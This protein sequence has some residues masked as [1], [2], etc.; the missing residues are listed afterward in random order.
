MT[1]LARTLV[2]LLA[3]PS[4]AATTA[5]Y[6]VKDLPG[7]VDAR[8][9]LGSL[10]VTIGNTSWFTANS[11]DGLGLQVWKT[12]GTEN[13]TVRVTNFI[14]NGVHAETFV[15][16]INGYILYSGQ[17]G[18][19]DA[20]LALDANGGPP[21]TVARSLF[22]RGVVYNG[23]LYAV[24]NAREVEGG[25]P[26]GLELW[27]TDGTT[28]GTTFADLNPGA[29]SSVSPESLALAGDWMVFAGETPA[30]KGIH[31][32]DGTVA[33]TS[34]LL[35]F[36]AGHDP[37]EA[38]ITQAGNRVVFVYRH[39]GVNHDQLLITDGTEDGT[40]S[41][42][43]RLS[44]FTPGPML[45]G[46]FLFTMLTPGGQITMWSS[47]GTLAGTQQLND[48]KGSPGT[49]GL[50]GAVVNG[51]YFF[52]ST[53]PQTQRRALFTT[54][55][56]PGTTQKVAD[57]ETLGSGG[58][59]RNGRFHFANDTAA[60]GNEWWVSDGTAG[61][62]HIV[63][64]LAAGSRDGV[65]LN[66]LLLRPDGFLAGVNG[67]FG[68]EPWIVDSNASGTRLLK[69]IAVDTPEPGS[70]P[71]KLRAAGARLYFL[72]DAPGHRV[73]GR[74]DGHSTG[75]TTGV[76][77]PT[78]EWWFA[79]AFV[80]GARYY[81]QSQSVLLSTDGT[82]GGTVRIS[83]D[84]GSSHAFRGGVVFEERS[85][86]TFRFSNGISSVTTVIERLAGFPSTGWKLYAANDRVWFTNGSALAVSDGVAPMRRIQPHNGTIG[87]IREVV[88]GPNATYFT[89][90]IFPD[91]R[92]WRTDGTDAGTR[93]VRT[94][95][96][97]PQDFIALPDKLLFTH[98]L[99]LWSTDGTE[100][101]T[102]LLGAPGPTKSCGFVTGSVPL[103]VGNQ[104]FWYARRANGTAALWKSNGTLIGTTE[105]A[106]F[107][108]SSSQGCVTMA[109]LDGRIYFRGFDTAHGAEP[110]VTDGT[111]AGTHLLV[112]L[113]PGTKGSDPRE[114]TTAGSH[115]FFSA[116][117][118]DRGRELWAIR[119]LT[120]RRAAAH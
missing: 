109:A 33:G 65:I 114:L 68:H 119:Q 108:S 100:A 35:A 77:T 86:S 113:Y 104:L 88:E 26:K 93:I 29:A 59:A 34:L 61:G 55:A 87:T 57:L 112:D 24:A 44:V 72:A 60:F 110:W 64:D 96:H 83:S 28:E 25:A 58:G 81:L 52:F 13:G 48:H 5:P 102:V 30:G 39:P 111:S 98:N 36:P 115:L 91:R 63:A 117:T 19:G 43:E 101:N 37:H 97:L 21:I 118:P 51:K 27:R 54:G 49:I 80:S 53:D 1:H 116:D 107:A 106:T 47:D 14:T 120:R 17:D 89:D 76:I 32:T 69:N 99:L 90:E 42:V 15:G 38:R 45:D 41:F 9:S 40:H 85:D 16:A 22:E 20:L 95:T 67:T 2:L 23:A 46:R 50:P 105:V 79:N 18:H 73:V 92:L 3:L 94:F 12:D 31:R 75:T 56:L 70:N 82:S 10:W 62:T 66:E 71:E 6:L 103:V 7:S 11:G 4:F 84:T 74:S 8:G 78:D